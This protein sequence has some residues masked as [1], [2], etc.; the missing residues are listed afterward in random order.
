[1]FMAN[2]RKPIFIEIDEGVLIRRTAIQT[3]KKYLDTALGH[4][5]YTIEIQYFLN[6]EIEEY[7]LYRLSKE[8]AEA[9]YDLLKEELE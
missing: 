6:G 1:M 7:C 4:N 9:K 8:S 5:Q 2:K 3:V